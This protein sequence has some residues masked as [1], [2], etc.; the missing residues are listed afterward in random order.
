[1]PIFDIDYILALGR[2]DKCWCGSKLK[3]KHCHKD[4]ERE[5][6]MSLGEKLA[7]GNNISKRETC[8]APENLLSD[9]DKVIKSHTISKSSALKSIADDSKHVLGHKHNLANFRKNNAQ[10]KLERIGINNAS[11]FKGFCK[12]HDK[13]FFSC[14][15]DSPFVGTKEQCIALTYR[16]VAKEIYAK[17]E[18]IEA[19]KFIR[20]NAD[21]GKPL[22][23]QI[24]IQ[25]EIYAYKLGSEMA[26]SELY[27]IKSNLYAELSDNSDKLF[28]FLVIESASPLPIVVSS[29]TNPTHDLKDEHLQDLANLEKAAEQLVFNAFTSNDKGFVVFSWLKTAE[30]IDRFMN[31]LPE[32]DKKDIFS[33]LVKLFFSSAENT[34]ISPDWWNTLN[35]E[36]QQKIEAL[37]KISTNYTEE[38]PRNVLTD[39]SIKF[40]SWEIENLYRVT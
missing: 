21:R 30:V 32:I 37:F 23:L 35:T 26:L 15:E 39:N 20:R 34:F 16:S 2:N 28:S 40:A 36:H 27:T 22:F 19:A 12:K 5:K 4:R 6:P 10:F 7:F 38:R 25:E 24:I 9:C 17:E 3:F 31:S 11:T 29:I 14:F 13:E 1:M 33:Y 18:A 8:Y